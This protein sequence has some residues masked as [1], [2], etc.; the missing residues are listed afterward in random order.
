MKSVIQYLSKAMTTIISSSTSEATLLVLLGSCLVLLAS[1]VR[2]VP[3]ADAIP[4]DLQIAIWTAPR[5]I[6][7]YFSNKP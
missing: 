6:V 3:G 1:L 4:K 2:R 5:E 7:E